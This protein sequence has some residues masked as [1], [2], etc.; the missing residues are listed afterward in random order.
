MLPLVNR[1]TL[2][3]HSSASGQ[4]FN[5]QLLNLEV[6]SALANEPA[7]FAVVVSKKISK[8]AVD[9]NH[10]KR[11]INEL[12]RPI[13]PQAKPSIGVIVYTKPPILQAKFQDIKSELETLFRQ[14]HVTA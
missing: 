11:Q 13:L 5:G 1:L 3:K 12:I 9:R 10:I 6:R 8:R 14:S 4:R 2:A 7:K